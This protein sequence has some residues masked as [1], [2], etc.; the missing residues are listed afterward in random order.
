MSMYWPCPLRCR[1]SSAPRMAVVAYMPVI[2]S[3]TAT[4]TF[5]GPAA[6]LPVRHAGDAHQPAHALEHEVVAG[7]R[8]V[9]PGL[10][11]AGDRAVDQPRVQ[12]AQAGIV[13][14]VLG[15]RA[16]LVVLD[17]DVALLGQRADQRLAFGRGQV[18]GDRFLAAVGRQE[19]GRI[20]A[21]AGV[22]VGA[23][24]GRAPGAR[25]V[26]FA[27]ALHLDD[28]GAHVGQVLRRPGPGQH[29]RQVEHAQVRQRSARR[30]RRFAHGGLGLGV[31]RPC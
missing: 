28:L 10:A 8:R 29:A 3:A 17:H 9:G 11:E 31:G 21:H 1:C 18:A 26:A 19:V 15:Q 13:E 24:E 30:R 20:S 22:L 23:E 5:I 4:P 12:R 7:A 2:R 25:V 14:P 16:D 27:G 6:G